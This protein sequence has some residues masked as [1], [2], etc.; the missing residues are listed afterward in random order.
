[1]MRDGGNSRCSVPD[2]DSLDHARVVDLN[3]YT[4]QLS[5]GRAEDCSRGFIH[6][7]PHTRDATSA[8]ICEPIWARILISFKRFFLSSID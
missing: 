7:Q 3:L 4:R 1:M 5:V 2:H 8:Y 6:R